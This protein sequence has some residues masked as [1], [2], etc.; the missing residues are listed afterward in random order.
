VNLRTNITKRKNSPGFTLIEILI[1]LAIISI[2][3][4]GMDTL[5]LATLNTAQQHYSRCIASQQV[6][7]LR[8]YLLREHALSAQ[9]LASWNAQNAKVLP[10]GEGRVSGNYPHYSV[11]IKW[12]S[13]R[14]GKA[15]WL[16]SEVTV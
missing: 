5:H 11:D 10:Q 4:L 6:R 3:L 2:M 15:G 7:N 14:G 12:G 8:V 16:H 9:T 13:S 1:S